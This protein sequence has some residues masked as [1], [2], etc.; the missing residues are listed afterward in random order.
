MLTAAVRDIAMGAEA[1]SEIDFLS[2][3]RSAGLPPPTLQAVRCDASGRRRYLDALWE[4]PDGR[5]VA[6]EIDGALHLAPRSWWND[7]VRQNE[8]TLGGVMVLRFPSVIL[9]TE[10]ATVIRQLRRALLGHY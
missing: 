8:V 4:L 5:K 9:R 6:V 7:Q 1:L 2:L 3:C 10:R